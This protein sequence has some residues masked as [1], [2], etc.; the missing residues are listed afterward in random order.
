MPTRG[1]HTCNVR[2]VHVDVADAGEFRIDKYPL[3][4]LRGRVE[5]EDGKAMHPFPLI[6]G[7]IDNPAFVGLTRRCC[8]LHWQCVAVIA[9]EHPPGSPT[10]VLPRHG[11]P[12]PPQLS[13]ARRLAHAAQMAASSSF[14]SCSYSFLQTRESDGGFWPRGR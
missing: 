2:A 11:A 3:P 14:N 7:V 6:V 13:P 4:D 9:A 12:Q 5:A 10:P 8:C 1:D